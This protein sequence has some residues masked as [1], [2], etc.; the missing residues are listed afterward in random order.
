MNYIEKNKKWAINL[1]KEWVGSTKIYIDEKL[2]FW[3]RH[4]C[5]LYCGLIIIQFG[6]RFWLKLELQ[7]VYHIKE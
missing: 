1:I 3:F 2:I 6:Y 5:G 4:N 7:Q